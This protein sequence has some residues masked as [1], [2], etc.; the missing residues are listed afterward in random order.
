MTLRIAHIKS[1]LS[2]LSHAHNEPNALSCNG[3][4]KLVNSRGGFRVSRG[5]ILSRVARY[6]GQPLGPVL[7]LIRDADEA[8]ETN[9]KNGHEVDSTHSHAPPRAKSNTLVHLGGSSHTKRTL[10]LSRSRA[11]VTEAY[12]TPSG[13]GLVFISAYANMSFAPVGM[14]NRS[15]SLHSRA[16]FILFLPPLFGAVLNDRRGLHVEGGGNKNQQDIN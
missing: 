4:N 8:Q 14:I 1:A 9:G 5:E 2:I 7:T 12:E 11:S 6:R 13:S 16:F 3:L 10:S 15:Y